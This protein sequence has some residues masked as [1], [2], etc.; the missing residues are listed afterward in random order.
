MSNSTQL[1]DGSTTP[2]LDHAAEST[3]HAFGAAQRSISALRDGTQN[4]MGRAQHAS[5]STVTYI[6]GEP[7][8]SMLMAAAAGATLMALVGLLTRSRDRS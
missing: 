8:K 7:V 4:L 3:D 5:D 2:M 6:K 1:S